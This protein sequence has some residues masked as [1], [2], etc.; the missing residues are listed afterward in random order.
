MSSAPTSVRPR[1]PLSTPTEYSSPVDPRDL[2]AKLNIVCARRRATETDGRFLSEGDCISSEDDDRYKSAGSLLWDDSDLRWSYTPVYEQRYRML[3]TPVGGLSPANSRDNLAAPPVA[4]SV[5]N[6]QRNLP[7]TAMEGGGTIDSA[8]NEAKIALM[9]AVDAWDEEFSSMQAEELPIYLLKGKLQECEAFKTAIRSHSPRL[10]LLGPPTY[11]DDLKN[12][13]KRAKHGFMALIRGLVKAIKDSENTRQGQLVNAVAASAVAGTTDNGP[14]APAPVAVRADKTPVIRRDAEHVAAKIEDIV[15]SIVEANVLPNSERSYQSFLSNLSALLGRIESAK[16]HANLTIKD[17]A[18]YGLQVEMNATSE[19]LINLQEHEDR[20]R[21]TEQTAKKQYGALNDNIREYLVKPPCFNGDAERG[22]DFFSFEKQWSEFR[23]QAHASD[24]KL[25]HILLNE[26]LSGTPKTTCKDLDTEKKVFVKLS[27]MYGNV[28]ILIQH[29]ITEIHRLKKCEG[30]RAKKRE[31]LIEMGSKLKSLQQLAVDHDREEKL[32]NSDIMDHVANALPHDWYEHLLKFVNKR[33]GGRDQDDSQTEDDEASVDCHIPS[34]VMYENLLKFLRLKEDEMTSKIEIELSIR[35]SK[36]VQTKSAPAAAKPP[37]PP[38]KSKSYAAMPADDDQPTPPPAAP[39]DGN[40]TGQGKAK[41]GERSSGKQKRKSNTAAGQPATTITAAANYKSPT[42]GKCKIC[43]GQHSYAYYCPSFIETTAVLRSRKCYELGICFKCLKADVTVEVGNKEWWKQHREECTMDWVCNVGTCNDRRPARKV[44]FLICGL[45]TPENESIVD[46]FLKQLDHTKVSPTTRFFVNHPEYFLHA[47]NNVPLHLAVEGFQVEPDVNHNIIYLVQNLTVGNESLLLFYDSGCH[48]GGVSDRAAKILQSTCVREGPT[49]LGVA[50]G[51]TL[52]IPYGDEQF[53]LPLVGDKRKCLVTGLRMDEITGDFPLW[54]IERAWPEIFSEFSKHF[55]GQELPDHPA[56]LGGRPVDIMVGI[57]YIKHFPKLLFTL[58]SGLALYE[59]QIA[60]SDGK[61][62]VFGGPHPSWNHASVQINLHS[63][64]MFFSKEM[65]AYYHGHM[66]LTTPMALP[67]PELDLELAKADQLMCLNNPHTISYSKD[68]SLYT[69]K[70]TAERLFSPELFESEINYRCLKCRNCQ[71]CRDSDRV[72]LL[73]LKEEKE[74]A[75]IEESVSFDAEKGR[76]WSSLPF[77]Q[78]P[79]DC[80]KPNK[81]IAEAIL[82]S[83]LRITATNETARLDVVAAHEKLRSR[84][85]VIRVADL[86]EQTRALIEGDN[87]KTVYHIP[88][89]MVWKQSISSPARMV[90]DA[91]SATPKGTSLNAILAKGQNQLSK[92]VHVLLKFRAGQEAFTAD[93]SCAYNN[94]WLHEQDFKYQLYLWKEDMDPAAPTEVYVVRTL[95]Y[96]VRPSGNLML[97][98]FRLLSEHCMKNFPQ[99]GQGAVALT[100]AYVDDLLHSSRNK[101]TAR[102]DAASLL[103]VLGL[104]GMKIKGFTFSGSQPPPDVSADQRTVGLLG[105]VW[106]PE[107]DVISVDAKPVFFGKVKRG[108]LPSLVEGDV[109]TAWEKVFT[110]RSVL[111]KMATLFDPLGLLAPLTA[112]FKLDFSLICSL[113]TRWDDPLPPEHL[114][115][116]VDNLENIQAAKSLRFPRS[117]LPEGAVSKTFELIVS[118]DASQYVAACCAHARVQM[119]D[120]RYSVKLLCARTKIVKSLTVPKAEMRAMTMAAGLA[121]ILRQQLGDQITDTIYVTDSSIALCQL[122]MDSRPMETLV[123]NCVIE[124]RR[125]SD[126]SDW[127]HIDSQ[128][129]VADIATRPVSLADVDVHSEWHSGKPWM[130]MPRDLMPLRSVSELIIASEDKRLSAVD[131]D[132]ILVTQ[133]VFSS[134]EASDGRVQTISPLVRERYKQ[135]RYLYDPN[136]RGWKTATRVMAYVLKFVRKTCKLWD[137]VY[138]PPAPPPH[139]SEPSQPLK[140]CL[141]EFD[142]ELGMSY[143][144][145]LATL[146][147]K[148]HTPEKLYKGNTVTKRGILFYAGR[149]ADAHQIETPVDKFLDLQPCNYVKPVADRYSPIAFSV[150]IFA[151]ASIAN[152]RTA[153]AT[154]NESRSIMYVFKGRSLANQIRELC[155]ECRVFK[156][157]LIEVEMS[158]IHETRLSIAPPFYFTQIDLAGPFSAYS[159]HNFRSTVKIWLVLFKCTASCAIAAHVIT[160]YST[161]AVLSAYTRFAKSYGHPGLI[162]IDRGTQLVAACEKMQISILDLAGQLNCKYQVGIDY[163]ACPSRAHN[164]MGMVERSIGLVKRLLDKTTKGLKL[165]IMSWETAAAFC[166]NELNN[167]PISLGSRTENLD[168]VDVITPSRLLLGR[169]N[170]RA[171]AGY[172]RLDVPSR[173]MRQRDEFYQAWWDIWRK[174]KL[175]DYIPQPSK[176]RDNSE[177]LQVNDIVA[178]IKLDTG[179]HQGGPVY[180]I[181]RVTAV[182]RSADGRVRTCEIEYKNAG[183]PKLFLKTRMSVRHVSVVHTESDLDI[184]LELNSAAKA[185]NE[186]YFYTTVK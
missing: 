170:R 49:N 91:S 89:R 98:A 60:A 153:S 88:W 8:V 30:P 162:M 81:H 97:A 152:H 132:V 164:H 118:A 29:K 110:R 63:A 57:R 54:D 102:E 163:R 86:D 77:I 55:P 154:L 159:E 82:A 142:L 94:V 131:K 15:E 18:E 148:Q 50:G 13:V 2:T 171:L 46:K 185:A 74:Q 146:E 99:H 112:K 38:A 167:F 69:L 172:P 166:S 33:R 66:V 184:I 140:C 176:W 141:S 5:T 160:K 130:S 68:P 62:L 173:M 133:Q 138:M 75:I 44:H 83:Q 175:T 136:K 177:E 93:I 32:Y 157:R 73:S 155:Q 111:S 26:S 92:L 139:V 19:H 116:W 1:T 37:P 64:Q 72:N 84:G 47:N 127:Y 85:F 10:E 181:G 6:V 3:R 104:A 168:C 95:I 150:M 58:P 22:L 78:N 161:D 41:K 180:K 17:A 40:V 106:E 96:G 27:R 65:R 149:I 186:H 12:G 107:E 103:Y 23:K 126:L 137:P 53:C 129:N 125:L 144:F 21:K 109:K 56:R 174:E 121:H 34:K 165:D 7:P 35:R 119:A 31:W 178:F 39:A 156:Q 115:T 123:R 179:D 76:L 134:C 25:L 51:K 143:Y 43:S 16:N 87:V 52:S 80:L 120:G 108:K 124:I 158:P 20:L 122:N 105:M 151:H 11:N 14:A 59:S 36:D 114:D 183:N 48:G 9:S 67:E 182:Q 147:V 135:Y 169:N 113:G 90:F 70:E 145:H 28:T 79:E 128:N 117:I 101:D 42:A 45:H 24:S 71:A 100:E 61:N 4:A